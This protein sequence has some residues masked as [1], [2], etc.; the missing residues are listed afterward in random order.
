MCGIFSI[1]NNCYDIMDIEIAFS[2]GVSRG[3][4]SSS[5]QFNNDGNSLRGDEL[6][7]FLSDCDKAIIALEILDRK[8]L[9]KLPK[10]SVIGK[11]GVGLDKLDL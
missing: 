11:Y 10:L 8:S 7:K 4:E 9:I 2:K 3:P 6:V 1:L 5:L